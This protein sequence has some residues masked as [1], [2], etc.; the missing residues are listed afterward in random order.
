MYSF[1]EYCS[2]KKY[3]TTQGVLKDFRNPYDAKMPALRSKDDICA[4]TS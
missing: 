1:N 3:F 2:T 4:W